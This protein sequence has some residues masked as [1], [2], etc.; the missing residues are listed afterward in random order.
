MGNLSIKNLRA[1]VEDKEILKGVDLEVKSG[2]IHALMGPNGSGKSTLAHLLMGKPNTLLT[3]GEISLDGE[4][5]VRLTPDQ[6][7]LGGLYLGFQHSMAI[8][9]VSILNF[10]RLARNAHDKVLGRATLTVKELADLVYKSLEKLCLPKETAERYLNEGFS[11]GE[12]K[13]VEILQM[14][15]IEPKIAILDEIDSGADV[16][17]LKTIANVINEMV[18][19]KNLGLVLIT[20]YPRLLEYVRPNFVHVF[21]DGKIVES[22]GIEL[23]GQVEKQG[24]KSYQLQAIT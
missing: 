17:A 22:G 15:I 4:D 10:L 2:E 7:S 23:A 13:K 8:P 24:Y 18:C 19:E 16:D 20:H 21:S 11:G 14:M 6:R 9:G 5:L 3:Q 1:T 12:K